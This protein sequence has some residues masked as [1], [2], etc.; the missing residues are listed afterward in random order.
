[1]EI[2]VLLN[3]RFVGKGNLERLVSLL[4]RIDEVSTG[5]QHTDEALAI[6]ACYEYLKHHTF[7]RVRVSDQPYAS[8]DIRSRTVVLRGIAAWVEVDGWHVINERGGE[9]V[10]A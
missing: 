1:M 9:G 6:S 8:I 3:G 2:D 5:V 4:R 10:T 7:G